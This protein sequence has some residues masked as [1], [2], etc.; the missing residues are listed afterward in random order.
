Y[1]PKDAGAVEAYMYCGVIVAESALFERIPPNPPWGIFT[2]LFAPM[3]AEGL[4]VFGFVHR[5][6]FRTVDDLKTCEQLQR[7]FALS[8]PPLSY[9]KD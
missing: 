1:L 2:G 4:A 8:M 6:F 9:R 3:V 7:E 5:G